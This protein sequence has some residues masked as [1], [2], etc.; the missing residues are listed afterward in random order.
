L[1]VA[2]RCRQGG[3]R[4]PKGNLGTRHRLLSCFF[5]Q[6]TDGNRPDQ[7]NPG[8]AVQNRIKPVD[9][10]HP[11]R[12][13]GNPPQFAPDMRFREKGRKADGQA[14]EQKEF[15]VVEDFHC[16]FDY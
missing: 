8:Q 11:D 5:K 2:T 1:I 15:P 7:Q 6:K 12:S 14:G 16:I 9:R 10:L 4:H 13:A 3:N